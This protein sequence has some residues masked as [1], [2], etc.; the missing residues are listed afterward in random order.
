GSSFSQVH[1]KIG[2]EAPTITDS[3]FFVK[4]FN[5]VQGLIIDG[6]ITAG[7]DIGSGGL[8]TT[9]LEMCFAD[10]NVAADFD[11]SSVGE[12]D[13]TKLLFSENIGI[14][15]QADA[16]VEQN[17]NEAGI[18][19]YKIGNVTEGSTVSITNGHFKV[20]LNVD[21]CRNTWFKTSYL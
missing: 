7:R 6:K 13:S 12:S 5:T 4:A 19:F 16:D 9:L 10:V 17:F 18:G 11:L 2:N 21:E 15:F 20:S 8:I 3:E 1:G 14:V